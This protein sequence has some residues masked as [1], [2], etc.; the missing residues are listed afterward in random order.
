[1][2]DLKPSGLSEMTGLSCSQ[3]AKRAHD[4]PG[5]HLT[6]GGHHRFRDCPALRLWIK[7]NQ[8]HLKWES[9]FRPL[10]HV[11]EYYDE[12]RLKKL[13]PTI[14]LILLDKIHKTAD[15][16]DDLKKWIASNVR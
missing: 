8:K 1:M 5:H 4:I 12:E 6:K 3:I 16:L 9:M 10:E 2:R 11:I 7:D 13:R 14:A 15:F